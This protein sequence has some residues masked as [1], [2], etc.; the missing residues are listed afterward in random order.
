[1]NRLT[2]FLYGTLGY[3]TFLATFLYAVGFIGNFDVPKSMDSPADGPW[4]T[5]LLVDLGL[6]SLFALQHSVMARPFFKRLLTRIFPAEVE[7]STY[8]LATSLAL[9]LLFWKWRPLGGTVWEVQNILGASLF[10][11]AYAFGWVVVLLAT[12]VISHFDLFGL[13]RVWLH[14]QGRPQSALKFATPLLYRVVRHPLYFGW[15]T[16]FWS[17]PVMTVTHLFFALATTV[18]ILFAIQ[19]EERDL[20]AKHPEY[21]DYR[22]QVPMI[23][24]G[25]P[26][27]VVI[28]KSAQ[29]IDRQVCGPFGDFV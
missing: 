21:I 18:Y 29:S 25:L 22:R 4:Q 7:R 13:R 9:L 14:L 2:I 24:P 10:Y 15:I 5:A 3:V 26:R 27:R 8:V 23:V 28:S 12:V 17:T 11:A 20:I 16:V 19:L 1:M 6:L